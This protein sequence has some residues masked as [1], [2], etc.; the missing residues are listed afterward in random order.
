MWSEGDNDTKSN[1][2]VE[3]RSPL[4]QTEE[5]RLS[6]PSQ[7][8]ALCLISRHAASGLHVNEQ[9]D[10]RVEDV[11]R[12]A[13]RA[14]LATHSSSKQRDFAASLRSA[15]PEPVAPAN[16]L[17]NVQGEI[18]SMRMAM[19]DF[20][21]HL[22]CGFDAQAGAIE[23]SRVSIRSELDTLR[24]TISLQVQQ[25]VEQG[26]AAVAA[27]LATTLQREFTLSLDSF[28]QRSAATETALRTLQ[29]QAE[30]RETAVAASL[31]A[32]QAASTARL[33]RLEASI[34]AAF[35]ANRTASAQVSPGYISF[36]RYTT[37]TIPAF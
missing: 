24:D 31:A 23:A 27:Q 10:S 7:L 35:E 30:A 33:D 12:D 26:V 29:L 11:A 25:S 6:L 4:T 21:H 17:Q 14:A 8:E 19:A 15:L 37:F 18:Q 28:A 36:W 2:T 34:V 3:L 9:I 1:S 16:Q 13:F 20:G 32:V 22:D 5:A